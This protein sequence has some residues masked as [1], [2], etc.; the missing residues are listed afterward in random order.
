MLSGGPIFFRS[1]SWLVVWAPCELRGHE[2]R[3]PL[4]HVAQTSGF[5]TQCAQVVKLRATNLA[6]P[7]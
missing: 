1:V 2:R 6:M 7:Q 5:T 4:L 3:A